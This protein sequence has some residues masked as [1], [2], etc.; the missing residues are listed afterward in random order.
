MIKSLLTKIHWVF[1]V[2]FGLDPIK[3]FKAIRG[4][5][6]YINDLFEFKKTYK[7][8]LFIKPCLGDRFDEGGSSKGE[9]F[10][11]DLIVA[12]WIHKKNPKIHVDVGSRFDGFVAHLASFR[13]VEVFDV[14][15]I[16]TEIP[17]I[18]FT[19]ADLMD[20]SK[21]TNDYCD[22]LSCLHAL[23][24]FGLG[25]Y[26]DPINAQGYVNGIQNLSLLLQQGGTL[27]LSVPIGKERV[28]F[29]ANYVF[30]PRKII[31]TAAINNLKIVSL[32]I[33][34]NDGIPQEITV[35]DNLLEKIGNNYY[36][37]GIFSF[38]KVH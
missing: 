33:I 5:P 15:P 11:Q 16:T 14:R 1:A 30:D 13:E 20:A 31:K 26:G 25:R 22:S 12:R 2:Q 9:Y 38:L 8:R 23:E 37:L 4:L 18:K 17:G 6:F 28:E 27:Y 3:F 19:Q 7:G 24:H 32:I 35:S 10:W 21:I 34:G 36:S 29:N